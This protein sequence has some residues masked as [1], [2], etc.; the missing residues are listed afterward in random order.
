MVARIAL[1]QQMRETIKRA[2]VQE[3]REEELA[4]DKARRLTANVQL[5]V[6]ASKRKAASDHLAA[7]VARRVMAKEEKAAKAYSVWLQTVYPAEHAARM[8]ATIKSF[9]DAALSQHQDA[10]ENLRAMGNFNRWITIPELWEPDFTILHKFGT[11]ANFDDKFAT[12]A[13]R[14]VRCSPQLAIFIENH[15]A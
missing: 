11:L 4:L 7:E 12:A 10:I 2:R 14:V 5:E 3:H 13:R 15:T 6:T 8:N 1:E 9:S